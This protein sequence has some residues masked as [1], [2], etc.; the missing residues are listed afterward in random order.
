MAYRHR[1]H[2]SVGAAV[3]STR[4]HA[5]RDEL[6]VKYEKYYDMGLSDIEIALLL[7]VSD[8]TV[9]RWRQRRGLPNQFMRGR[10][11]AKEESDAQKDSQEGPA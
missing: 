4:S 2:V 5:E 1:D 6:Y 11:R 7:G 10:L 9:A 8:R 3:P